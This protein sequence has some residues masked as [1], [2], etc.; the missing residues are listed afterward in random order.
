M[1]FSRVNTYRL[2]NEQKLSNVERNE[3]VKKIVL[4][5]PVFSSSS[6]ML[7]DIKI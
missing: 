1:A 4:S 6:D 5:P 2:M 7:N 3:Q